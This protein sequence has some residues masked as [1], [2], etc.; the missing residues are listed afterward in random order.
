M[1]EGIES[2][3]CEHA[4]R[5]ARAIEL[6]GSGDVQ[7]AVKLLSHPVANYYTLYREESMH[8]ERSAKLRGVIEE[9]ARTNQVVAAQIIEISNYQLKRP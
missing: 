9:L 2:S 3:D 1:V 6:I 5:A 4:A 8:N 7:Q